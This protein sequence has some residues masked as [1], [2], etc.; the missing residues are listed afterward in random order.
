[1]TTVI[2]YTSGAFS[3]SSS[4]LTG[5][6]N[7][8]LTFNGSGDTSY[9]TQL[10]PALGGTGVDS[11]AYTGVAKVLA[12]VWSAS[13]IVNADINAAA[14]IDWTKMAALAANSFVTT[15]GSGYVTT[16]AEPLGLTLGGTG[17]SISSITQFR[18]LASNTAA[19]AF[20]TT[21]AYTTTA[22]ASNLVQRDGSAGIAAPLLTSAANITL[23]PTGGNVLFGASLTHWSPGAGTDSYKQTFYAQSTS[24]TPVAA[25]TIATVAGANN[26]TTYA[27][28][29]LVALGTAS[30]DAGALSFLVFAKNVGGTLTVSPTFQTSKATN[31]A[32]NAI[33]VT[34][35]ASSA[36]LLINVVGVTLTTID[37]G[38][39]L[40]VTTQEF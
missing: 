40:D 19:N 21:L 13:S 15:N 32:L 11:S 8:I 3:G 20:D 22:V 34:A 38:L 37:W 4:L 9:I 28:R 6:A 30:G 2:E 5:T 23:T 10:S 25:A 7:T 26:G 29:G 1:M 39:S 24:I 16:T 27:L 35:T 31:T 18:I 14:A 36:N 17:L 12:G 33:K